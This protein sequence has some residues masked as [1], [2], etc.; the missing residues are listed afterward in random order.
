LDGLVVTGGEPTMMEDIEQLLALVK[1]EGVPVKLD[2]NGTRPDVLRTLIARGLVDF[3]ALDVKACPER[4]ASATGC[5]DVWEKVDRTIHTILQSGIAHEFR[6]TC[7]PLAVAPEDLQRIAK[8]LRGGA[9]YVLQQF[10][11]VKT[12]DPAAASVRP[13]ES[14]TLRNAADACSRYLPTTV[15]GA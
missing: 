1:A 2:T 8:R 6:T 9:R 12:L 14:Q 10:R 11:P 3:V 15:R 13:Y 5:R 7:Y 4:Y